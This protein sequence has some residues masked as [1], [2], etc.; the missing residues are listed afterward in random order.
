MLASGPRTPLAVGKWN[1]GQNSPGKGRRWA[2]VG[3]RPERWG[4][5]GIGMGLRLDCSAEILVTGTRCVCVCV[6]WPRSSPVFPPMWKE[7]RDT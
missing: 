6:S 5:G 1:K 2:A 7:V 4:Q 3:R